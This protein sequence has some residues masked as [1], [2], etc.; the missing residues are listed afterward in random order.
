MQ[1]I[2]NTNADAMKAELSYRRSL[3]VGTRSTPHSLPSRRWRRHV[4]RP[5]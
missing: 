4:L 2:I 3:L 1:E 5:S